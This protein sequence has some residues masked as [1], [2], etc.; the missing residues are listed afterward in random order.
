M[1]L[2]TKCDILV[3]ENGSCDG[4]EEYRTQLLNSL[5]S[6]KLTPAQLD[7]LG[8]PENMFKGFEQVLGRAVH[9]KNKKIMLENSPWGDEEG[10]RF[11]TFLSIPPR[12][13]S[14]NE[15]LSKMQATL[16]EA[17]ILVRRRDEAYASQ[18]SELVK[19]NP[20]AKILAMMGSGHERA[21]AKYLGEKGVTFK[22]VEQQSS[23]PSTYRSIALERAENQESLSRLD[24]LRCLAE[25]FP[26]RAFIPFGERGDLFMR[27]W[28]EGRSEAQL[29]VFLART[30][31]HG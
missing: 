16:N 26:L 17:A 18:L 23:L 12:A 20:S 10:D 5:A 14:L 31:S 27:F 9:N 30:Y 29:T 11:L 1:E 22:P 13:N 15:A 24:L 4:T 25:F 6:G 19:S 2:L 28:I 21:L 7:A 3:V 8:D